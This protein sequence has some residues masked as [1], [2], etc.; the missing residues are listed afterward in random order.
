M[1]AERQVLVKVTMPQFPNAP[2]WEMR[3]NWDE[4]Y[5]KDV[6]YIKQDFFSKALALPKG[7]GALNICAVRNPTPFNLPLFGILHHLPQP[8]TMHVEAW[9]HP[10]TRS[11]MR[12]EE[13]Y[14]EGAQSWIATAPMALLDRTVAPVPASVE[15][16]DLQE[17]WEVPRDTGVHAGNGAPGSVSGSES[18]WSYSWGWK[19]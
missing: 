8:D 4:L 1:I 7:Q 10:G 9:I 11:W 15:D 16:Q 12:L 3:Y 13:M 2:S 5:G 19:T 6:D 17:V 14:P 18:G